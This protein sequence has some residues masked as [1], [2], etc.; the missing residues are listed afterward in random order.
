MS[1]NQFWLSN[2]IGP[3]TK[4]VPHSEIWLISS[5]CNAGNIIYEV[6]DTNDYSEQQIF[7]SRSISTGSNNILLTL[8]IGNVWLGTSS[9]VFT[10]PCNPF[11]GILSFGLP[12]TPPSL[13]ITSTDS[14]IFKSSLRCGVD[15]SSNVDPE[16][17]GLIINC[18]ATQTGS[19]RVPL[20]I[21][22][23][24]LDPADNYDNDPGNDY[25]INSDLI[26]FNKSGTFRVSANGAYL[27]D[28]S[29]TIMFQLLSPAFSIFAGPPCIVNVSTLENLS[30]FPNIPLGF[31]RP[32]AGTFSATQN[33]KVNAGQQLAWLVESTGIIG[34]T[35]VL[36]LTSAISIE[37]I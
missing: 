31:S 9:N 6:S 19:Y 36:E 3:I 2:D 21:T 28:S 17:N 13:S 30:S 14:G 5:N 26:T 7:I 32:F 16:T 22:P 23:I 35:F 11:S 27:S 25:T 10:L 20:T 24:G 18:V 4:N 15:S 12:N 1:Q 8:P 33:I 37:R 29:K 34:D